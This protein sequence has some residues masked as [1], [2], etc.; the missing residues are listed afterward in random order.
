VLA[1][2]AVISWRYIGD[3]SNNVEEN[4]AA[5]AKRAGSQAPLI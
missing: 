4:F 1:I 3:V 5:A 2:T